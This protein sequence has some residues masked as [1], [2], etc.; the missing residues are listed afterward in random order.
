MM[1]TCSSLSTVNDVSEVNFF[2]SSF[3]TM[4]KH[5]EARPGVPVHP[6]DNDHL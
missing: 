2:Y 6:K 4:N 1:P 3:I 5:D